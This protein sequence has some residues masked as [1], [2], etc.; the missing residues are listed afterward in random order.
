MENLTQLYILFSSSLIAATLLPAGSEIIITGLYLNAKHSALTLITVATIGN[1]LGS[2]I[3]Y[4]MGR[5]LIKFQNRKWFPFKEK[6]IKKASNLFQKYGIFSLLFAW[7][8]IIGD[9]VTLI[10]GMF[11]VNIFTFIALVSIGKAARYAI[12]LSIF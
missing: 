11:R 8:P 6:S 10:A 5:Y 2:I 9:P 1:V 4:V 7:L 3:N 12:L